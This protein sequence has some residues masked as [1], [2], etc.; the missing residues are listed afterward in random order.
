MTTLPATPTRTVE[1]DRRLP[2]LGGFAPGVLRIEL[3]RVLRNRRTLAFTLI[4]PASSS[5]SSA[6]RR[7]GRTWTTAAR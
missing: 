7:A 6:C 5:S 3:R 4:M 1:P 2:A